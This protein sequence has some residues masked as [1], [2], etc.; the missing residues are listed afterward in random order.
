MLLTWTFFFVQKVQHNIIIKHIDE[1]AKGLLKV[2]DHIVAIGDENA[3]SWPLARVV[4]RLNDFRVPV[5]S[6]VTITF[7]RYVRKDGKED[8]DE[9]ESIGDCEVS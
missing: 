7:G 3:T 4:Q 9:D 6:D 8:R 2:N 5:G 1:A